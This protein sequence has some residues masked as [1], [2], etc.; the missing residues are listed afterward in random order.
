[1]TSILLSLHL[2]AAIVW[3]GG[4]F[5][6]LLVLRPALLSL[7]SPLPLG[8]MRRAL[9]RFLPMVWIC[10]ALLVAT[11]YACVFLIFGGFAAAGWHVRVMHA[12]GMTMV[13]LFLLL[14][15]GPWRR[16]RQ[17]LDGGN[18]EAAVRSLGLIR[19]IAMINLLLGVITACVSVT[20]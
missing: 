7:P 17:H 5:F 16:F 1:M 12:S 10:V 9:G 8:V 6:M 19:R 3:V 11:G 20:G 13:A 15:F 2:L 18:M 14:W 4:L